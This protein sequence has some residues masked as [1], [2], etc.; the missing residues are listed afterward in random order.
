[1]VEK[2]VS[3]LFGQLNFGYCQAAGLTVNKKERK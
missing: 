1:M 2:A 3:L